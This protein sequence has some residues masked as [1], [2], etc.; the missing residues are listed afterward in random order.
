VL[1]EEVVVEAKPGPDPKVDENESENE[2]KEN[3][4][5]KE[6]AVNGRV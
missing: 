2:M 3:E 4:M 5:A 1:G 6:V